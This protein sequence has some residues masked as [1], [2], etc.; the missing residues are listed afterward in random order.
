MKDKILS[1]LLIQKLEENPSDGLWKLTTVELESLC[2]G[3]TEFVIEI[4]QRGFDEGFDSCLETFRK[5]SKQL[6]GVTNARA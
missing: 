6:L 3:L 1:N 4:Y 5:E 2:E